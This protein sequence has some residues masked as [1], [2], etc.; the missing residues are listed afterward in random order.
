MGR[1]AAPVA[2]F[3]ARV[4][5]TFGR[6][7][8]IELPDGG[9]L[10]ATRRGKRG[11]VVV[12]DTVTASLASADQA[13]IESIEARTSLLFRADAHRIK[14]LAAN[15]DQV[16]VMFAS[17][18]AFDRDFI[19]KALVAA[20]CAGIEAL[21]VRNKIEL[22]DGQEAQAVLDQVAQL[23][24]RTLA[25]SCKLDSRPPTVLA[26]ALAGKKSLLIGQS[27]MGKSTLI[28]LL[29]PGAAA[30]TQ[31]YSQRANAGRQTTTAARWFALPG[32]GA[33]VDT[34]GFKEFGLSHLG[35]SQIAG[36]FPE[37]EHALAQSQCRFLDCRHV[38]EPICVVRAAANAGTFA[39]A[40]YRFYRSLATAAAR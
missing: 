1:I 8:L 3:R 32:G 39:P 27:G 25:V 35:R 38:D 2:K 13:V 21:V 9:V 16:V 23:G 28:N 40:R 17:R 11:D 19:W 34:P 31:E 29:V 18:P 7:V 15:V 22:P 30:R 4:V 20:H 10:P 5:A 12:G 36:A 26:D 37:I 6:T 24:W 14:E 33:I